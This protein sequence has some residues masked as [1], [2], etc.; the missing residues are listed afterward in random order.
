MWT[1]VSEEQKEKWYEILDSADDINEVKS[2]LKEM[3]EELRK[4]WIQC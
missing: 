4:T 1:I 2:V 3:I